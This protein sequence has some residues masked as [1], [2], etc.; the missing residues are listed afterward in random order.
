[1]KNPTMIVITGPT[2]SGKSALAIEVAQKLGT[3]IISAD[4]R[5][6]Y[7]GIPIVTAIPTEE[8]RK[9]V[10]HHFLEKLS[11]DR[12]YSAA[13]FEEEAL[14]CAM[15]I[16]NRCGSVVV[17]GGSMLYIDAL[18][19]GIDILPTV[20]DDI[21][22]G[23]YKEFEEKGNDWLLNELRNLDPDYYKTVDLKN[24]KRVIHAIEIIRTSGKT[25]SSM[26]T[27]VHRKRP[28]EIKKYL[29]EMPREILFERINRRVDAMILSG[30]EEEARS[31]YPYRHLNSLNTVGLK[32]MFQYFNGE[33]DRTTAI[34]R[35]KKNT[36][37]YSKK[38]MFWWAKDNE[39]IHVPAKITPQ[40]SSDVHV[41][42]ELP[43]LLSP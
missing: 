39:I 40:C 2:A 5:Q 17:C 28:F 8:E 18:C 32:E 6:I 9:G 1:M 33:L 27:G 3:E 19:K 7:K 14:K 21:R 42:W 15:E 29:L 4:S 31:V 43:F 22:I 38:Q 10:R 11:L 23:L 37:V 13:M 24:T 12:Y 26:R 35:I 41:N 20:P 36:R 25:Y 34:E 30:L 16:M